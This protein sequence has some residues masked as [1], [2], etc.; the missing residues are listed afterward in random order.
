MKNAIQHPLAHVKLS[1]IE[2]CGKSIAGEWVAAELAEAEYPPEELPTLPSAQQRRQ[3]L[4][5]RLIILDG[6]FLAEL[7]L[8]LYLL[9]HSASF[10]AHS[11]RLQ[12]LSR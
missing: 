8:L 9:I 10:A 11:R 6:K 7:R 5:H 12:H 2:T 1:T 3:A 4:V